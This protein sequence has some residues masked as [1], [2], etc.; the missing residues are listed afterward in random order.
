MDSTRY[1][2][3]RTREEHV[4]TSH[5]YLPLSPSSQIFFQQINYASTMKFFT[6]ALCIASVSALAAPKRGR[7]AAK[8]AAPQVSLDGTI[9]DWKGMTVGVK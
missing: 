1:V 8:A 7:K 9:N 4:S 2:D 3:V 6:A 5:L